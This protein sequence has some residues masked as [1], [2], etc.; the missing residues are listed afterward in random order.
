MQVDDNARAPS[1]TPS[2]A[3]STTRSTSSDVRSLTL[4]EALKESFD[5]TLM[6]TSQYGDLGTVG[7]RRGDFASILGL[8]AEVARKR[9]EAALK[10]RKTTSKQ[11][12]SADRDAKA[13]GFALETKRL[14]EE[15]EKEAAE[16]EKEEEEA[17][18]MLD[19]AEEIDRVAGR[20][21]G[22]VKRLRVEED[23]T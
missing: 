5:S 19:L 6:A 17:R 13:R 1:P 21:E 16:Q 22:T 15:Q 4:P 20:E 14:D 3:S 2:S 23:D 9:S 8:T 7:T 11:A 10:A 18:E 12:S